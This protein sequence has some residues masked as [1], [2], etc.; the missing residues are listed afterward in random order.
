MSEPVAESK[1][2]SA[3]QPQRQRGRV[4][5]EIL[6]KALDSLLAEDS[7][8]NV[9]LYQIAERAGVP[10][11]SVY[12]FFPNKEAALLA[13][14][15]VHHQAL[16]DLSRAP[17]ATPPATWQEMV[18]RKISISADY[19]NKNPSVLRLFLGA[20]IIEEVK[21]ADI[22]QNLRLAEARSALF[23]MYFEMP[24]IADWTSK[25]ATYLSIIDGIFSLSYS[26]H[27]TITEYYVAETQLATVSYLRCYLPEVLTLKALPHSPTEK[28]TNLQGPRPKSVR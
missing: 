21:T 12:H 8:Q 26:Q 15:Q 3:R 11:A 24:F 22:S 25:L 19:H 4:R 13:L 28:G 2:G 16:Y 10:S 27:G 6:L 7:V 5:F 18:K 14:A 20:N 23:N 17:L 1:R 9:G